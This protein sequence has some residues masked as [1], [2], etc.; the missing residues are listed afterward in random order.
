MNVFVTGSTGYIG[1]ALIKK[2]LQKKVSITAL[3]RPGSDRDALQHPQIKIVEGDLSSADILRNGMQSCQQVYHLAAYARVWS[4]DKSIYRQVNVEGTQHVLEAA[5]AAGV[6]K[7]VFTSTAGV[8]GPAGADQ[9][10]VDENTRRVQPFFN[11]Y[12]QTKWEAEQLCL[13]Y[14]QE[15]S[16]SVTIVNPSRVYGPGADTESNAISKLATLFLRGKWRFIPG[17]GRSLGNYTYLDDVVDGHVAAM[18]KGRSGERY[19]LGGENV[20]FDEFFHLLRKLSDKDV[21]LFHLP[22]GVML[23]FAR[24]ESLKA[25]LLNRRPL[26]TPDWVKKYLY[27]WPLTSGKAMRELGYSITSLPVGLGKTILQLQSKIL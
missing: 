10:P 17:D 22:I 8:L 2:L 23:G 1:Q 16:L 26:I 4:K 20:S 7:V 21:T 19:I 3:C 27:D 24:V 12:E 25:S 18:E 6:R 11:E 15:T 9:K 5:S 13:R 14:A